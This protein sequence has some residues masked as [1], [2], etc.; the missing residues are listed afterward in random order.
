MI[1]ILT[2]QRVE[3]GVG[4]AYWSC[5]LWLSEAGEEWALP[6][7]APGDLLEGKLL[8]WFEGR[9]GELW[10]VAREKRYTMDDLPVEWR[11]KALQKAVGKTDEELLAVSG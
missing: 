4:P 1:E 8:A 11:V 10:K 7:T 9:A 6:A 2:Q 5:W 3:D